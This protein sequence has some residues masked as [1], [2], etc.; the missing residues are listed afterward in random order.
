M[1]ETVGIEIGI[2]TA[3]E[4][5]LVKNSFS[6]AIAIARILTNADDIVTILVYWLIMH[7]CKGE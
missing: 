7:F 1:V 5:R 2:A 4:N 6:I 3:I